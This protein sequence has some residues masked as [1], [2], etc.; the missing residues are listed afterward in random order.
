MYQRLRKVCEKNK[1]NPLIVFTGKIY[2]TKK[3]E[4]SYELKDNG[5]GTLRSR[6]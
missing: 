4:N 3:M 1:S 2:R 6:T 5:H